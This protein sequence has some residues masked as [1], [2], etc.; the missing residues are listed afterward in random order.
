MYSVFKTI[1]DYNTRP[2]LLKPEALHSFLLVIYSLTPII[3]YKLIVC[4]KTSLK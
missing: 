1:D 2:L 4:T 3:Y